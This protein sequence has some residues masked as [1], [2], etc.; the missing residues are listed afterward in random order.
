[1]RSYD[2]LADTRCLRA[3]PDAFERLRNEYHLRAEV[4]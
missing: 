1:M 4:R 3:N 2:P